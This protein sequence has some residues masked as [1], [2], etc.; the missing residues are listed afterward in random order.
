MWLVF[1]HLVTILYDL[2]VVG[3]LPSYLSMLSL[4][5]SNVINNIYSR[6]PHIY[7]IFCSG[8]IND[9]VYWSYRNLSVPH[10]YI[11]FLTIILMPMSIYSIV[12]KFQIKLVQVLESLDIN[13][14][15][16]LHDDCERQRRNKNDNFLKIQ[17]NYITD[18]R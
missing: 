1:L 13:R 14:W 3:V 8:R 12:Y 15:R 11:F 17:K 6:Y 16:P 4:Q 7:F 5:Y 9:F 2:R 10:I 18:L